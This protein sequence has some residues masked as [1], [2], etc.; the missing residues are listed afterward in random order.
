[1]ASLYLIK[2]EPD[3]ERTDPSSPPSPPDDSPFTLPAPVLL[4]LRLLRPV[5]PQLVPLFVLLALIPVIVSFSLFSGWY[6]WKNVAV[7]WQTEIYLQYGD[8]TPPYAEVSLPQLSAS[9]P[10]DISLHLVIPAS[11]SNFELGNFMASLTLATPSNRTL[12]TVR[13]PAIALPLRNHYLFSS[14]SSSINLDIFLLPSF[15]PGTSRVN[16]RV[17]LGRHD[18]WRR[19]GRGEIRELSVVTASLKGTVLYKG[20]RGLVSR[21]PVTSA[22][23]SSVIFFMVSMLV[24]AACLLPTIK[25]QLPSEEET[26]ITLHPP[27]K[28]S[29]EGKTFR[30][31]KRQR[32]AYPG[33][34]RSQS[35]AYKTEDVPIDI[36]PAS[37][38]ERPLRRRRSRTSDALYDSDS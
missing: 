28:T 36:P 20:V 33:E 5:A 4:F 34:S 29:R 27:K 25:W 24:L 8:G 26:V 17:E 13:R 32:V 6:V 2:A 21:F 3:D 38:H 12:A 31:R 16:A 10:Y 35:S 11:D 19:L 22:V 15:V 18:E 23:I 14:P 37:H 7:G 1:M 9:Q 30:A